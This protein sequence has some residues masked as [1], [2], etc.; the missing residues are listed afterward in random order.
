MVTNE[1][2][3]RKIS[4]LPEATFELYASAETTQLIKSNLAKHQ[5]QKRD[6]F[7][8]LVGDVLLGLVSSSD[9][10]KLLIS[11]IGVSLEIAEQIEAELKSFFTHLDWASP[12]P[13]ADKEI[14]E[15][16]EL[17]P[18]RAVLG[19]ARPLTREDVLRALRPSSR[20]MASDINA[21]AHA[22]RSKEKRD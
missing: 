7:V 3:Q 8:D 19:D 5:I 4:E 18:E 20:T 22:E 6:S 15:R 13:E 17:K 12:F 11:E 10:K 21:I 14:R 2:R 1:E 9:F 16:L